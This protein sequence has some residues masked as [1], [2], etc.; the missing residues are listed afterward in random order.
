LAGG[1][2]EFLNDLPS[3]ARFHESEECSRLALRKS[4]EQSAEKGGAE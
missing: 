3:L 2:N 1:W 4:V